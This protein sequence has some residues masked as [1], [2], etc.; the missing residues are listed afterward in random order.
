MRKRPQLQLQPKRMEHVFAMI[1]EEMLAWPKVAMRRMFGMRGFYRGSAIFALLPDKRML[2]RP[3][4]IG[5]KLAGPGKKE[6]AKWTFF[7]LEDERGI[8]A[9][10]ALLAKAFEKAK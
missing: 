2:E 4:S 6:S 9:A 8:P 10:L 1:A 5:Y 7:D 3:N